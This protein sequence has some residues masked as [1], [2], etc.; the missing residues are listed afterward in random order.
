LYIVLQLE[1]YAL[2]MGSI[3]LLFVLSTVMYVTRK[4][5]WYSLNDTQGKDKI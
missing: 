4:I 3:G 5:D 1:D 2:I